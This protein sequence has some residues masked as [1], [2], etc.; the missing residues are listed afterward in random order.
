MFNQ[1]KVE[2]IKR[3]YP[4]GTR[5]LLEKMNDP[6][7]PVPSG[8]RGT[9]I[10]VDD[11]GQLQMQW[12]NG[13]TLALIPGKDWFRKLTRQELAA[14]QLLDESPAKPQAPMIG[15]N[16]NIY[17]LLGIAVKTLQNHGC[18]DEA[19]EMKNRVF[20]SKSYEEALVI[21]MEYVEPVR[22]DQ[23]KEDYKADYEDEDE[24]YDY[25]PRL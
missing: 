8:T 3:R 7:S 15:A 13:K 12:D 1:N 2:S 18:K 25:E 23:I 5:I 9:V 19:E 24:D 17:N 22:A 20:K 11:A 16:G 14:E 21:L 10:L 6:Y 4:A